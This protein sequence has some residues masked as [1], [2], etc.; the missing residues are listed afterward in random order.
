MALMHAA[1][2]V[3]KG[4]ALGEPENAVFCGVVNPALGASD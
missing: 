4:R 3:F 1:R 2:S